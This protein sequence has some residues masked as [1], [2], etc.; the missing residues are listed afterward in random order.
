MRRFVEAGI[1]A[2]HPGRRAEFEE[3]YKR[4][5]VLKAFERGERWSSREL[6]V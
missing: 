1:R 4:E 6:R 2:C 5:N 3:R